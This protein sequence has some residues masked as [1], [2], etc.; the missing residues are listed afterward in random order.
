ME[1]QAPK[2]VRVAVSFVD[3]SQERLLF[4]GR[5]GPRS[6]AA[7]CAPMNDAAYN[8]SL[9]NPAQPRMVSSESKAPPPTFSGNLSAASSHG[10]RAC[11]GGADVASPGFADDD[12]DLDMERDDQGQDTGDDS[13]EDGLDGYYGQFGQ[14]DEAM[15]DATAEQDSVLTAKVLEGKSEAYYP[16][17]N[18]EE[19]QMY[20]WDCQPGVAI[21]ERKFDSLISMI[22]APGFDP[23]KLNASTGRTIRARGERGIPGVRTH[24]LVVK[25]THKTRSKQAEKQNLRAM[26]QLAP[27]TRFAI[28]D[29]ELTYVSVVDTLIRMQH[30]PVRRALFA[31]PQ[32]GVVRPVDAPVKAFCDT[33]F[34][35]TPRLWSDL[36]SFYHRNQQYKLG[37]FVTVK[38]DTPELRCTVRLDALYYKD[39]PRLEQW[40]KDKWEQSQET[41][42]VKPPLYATGTVFILEKPNYHSG[43]GLI[44]TTKLHDFWVE[45]VEEL[46]R[47]ARCNAL[48]GGRVPP[49]GFFCR[50][51]LK[52]D[53]SHI[54]Y[55]EAPAPLTY[56]EW[57]TDRGTVFLWLDIFK[58]GFTSASSTVGSTDGVYGRVSS[59]HPGVA[60]TSVMIFPIM[61]IPHG[62]NDFE[63]F[64]LLRKDLRR[65]IKGVRFDDGNGLVRTLKARVSGL[66]A[67]NVESMKLCRHLGSGALRNCRGCWSHMDDRADGQMDVLDHKMI[68]RLDQTEVVQAQMAHEQKA[69]GMKDAQ[70]ENVQQKYGLRQQL[71]SYNQC[72]IDPFLQA[73]RDPEHMIWF[74]FIKTLLTFMFD[75]LAG[76]MN[77][78][79]VLMLRDFDWPKKIKPVR[80]ILSRNLGK[81]YTMGMWRSLAFVCTF[82]LDGLVPEALL[83]LLVR[84]VHW[85]ML[86]YH[87]L[88]PATLIVAQEEAREIVDL[89]PKL[90]EALDKPNTHGILQ[91]AFH[92]LPALMNARLAGTGPFE[93]FH[94]PFKEGGHGAPLGAGGFEKLATKRYNRK[95]AL[96]WA[97]HGA[98]WGG[99]GQRTGLGPGILNMKDHRAGR[100]HLPHPMLL[101][102]A[103]QMLLDT[104]R[105]PLD[106]FLGK[107]GSARVMVGAGNWRPWK[108]ARG[109]VGVSQAVAHALGSSELTQGMRG[110]RFLISI[111]DCLAEHTAVLTLGDDVAL[112]GNRYGRVEAFACLSLPMVAAGLSAIA[113]KPMH[114][115]AVLSMYATSDR[116]CPKRSSILVT[117]QP[118]LEVVTLQTLQE[119]VV[120]THYCD[121]L[122]AELTPKLYRALVS[123]DPKKKKKYMP[124]IKAH[125]CVVMCCP[126]HDQPDCELCAGEQRWK[127]KMKHTDTNWYEVLGKMAGFYPLYK[128]N[129]RNLATA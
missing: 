40:D 129:W 16:F 33:P 4:K 52:Q 101:K 58:D 65:L 128:K 62:C 39:I 63:C 72:G 1:G 71:N 96:Q 47:V 9:I 26:P 6:K 115:V 100:E 42:D 110:E 41:R 43:R 94:Q 106:K 68:R 73:W 31:R 27:G 13:S 124:Q 109:G 61:L 70:L 95:A 108:I 123:A 84:V 80:L 88:T 44:E 21:P 14:T 56:D 7:A 99:T 29:I 51:R 53:G 85:T 30:D 120:I 36:I 5:R 122:N 60:S 117:K 37:D 49:Q 118:G 28:R 121:R 67:D 112:H 22:T 66:P 102:V 98:E 114:L 113:D 83:Q 23:S 54:Q 86:V 59:C 91:F 20:I 48:R 55:E 12:G 32:H 92:T 81:G 125:C 105:F 69:R 2:R 75:G 34:A 17:S 104:V 15:L 78:N 74:G 46:V 76:V 127:K 93:S 79:F 10:G 19:A 89:G 57:E 82:M 64:A 45:D 77:D 3:P 38:T 25:Q 97:L 50:W 18:V 87:G 116:I 111:S 35:K 11:S 119:H 107:G 24:P 8:M 103:P 126:E 90:V